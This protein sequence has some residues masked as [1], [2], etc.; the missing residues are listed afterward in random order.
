ML[1]REPDV[2]EIVGIGFGPS[3]L[4]LAVAVREHPANL[5]GRPISAIFFEKQPEFGWHKSMLLPNVTMQVSFLKDLATFRN[6]V[7]RFTFVSYLHQ[8]GR[9]PQFVNNQDFFPTREEF[10]DYLE[11]A[12]SSFNDQVCYGSE[13]VAIRQPPGV[14]AGARGYLHL[15]VS[16]VAGAVR[17]V[18]ARNVVISTGL[19]PR[20]PAGIPT[21]DRVWHSSQFLR[22]F[23]NT[24]PHQLKSVAVVG[25]GQ[26]AAEITRF[27]YDELTHAQIYS[28]VPSYGYSLADDTPFA[29]RVF[30]PD[31][32]DHY[33]FGTAQTRDAFWRYHRNTN[34]SV[35]D[36]DVIRDLFRRLYLESVHNSKRLQFLNL[37]RLSG[38]SRAGS[39]T[40]LRLH[41]LI[42]NETQ[43]L[44][45]DAVVCA[46]GYDSMEPATL[47]SALGRHCLRDDTGR[48]Q[49]ARDYRLMTSPSLPG[50]IY[51]QGGTEHSHGLSASLLSNI[52]IRSG[53]IVDSIVR[54]RTEP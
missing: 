33:Y 9:L 34:Y 37:T 41:S 30:D 17:T 3:N 46:T 7:S 47:L 43:E 4:S 32:I 25:A 28:I 29:N 42:D 6:P 15:E 54:R 51:L 45:V 11:W 13:V 23:K 5:Q 40:R 50:G 24:D 39:E 31:A 2:H 1:I 35:V 20:M 36:S 44:S 52:A 22:K 27:L 18:A 14:A 48:L 38:I 16:D 19:V 21:D 10:H 26:S 8:V 49:V 53:E 12:E